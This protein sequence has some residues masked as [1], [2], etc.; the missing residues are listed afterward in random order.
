MAPPIQRPA[1]PNEPPKHV[2]AEYKHRDQAVTCICGW[3]GSSAPSDAG[4]SAWSGHVAANRPT[5]R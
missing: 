3:R 4:A 1:A 2:I 5:K